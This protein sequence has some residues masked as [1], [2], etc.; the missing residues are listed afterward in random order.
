M[1]TWIW[2][3]A[4]TGRLEMPVAATLRLA[5]VV[6]WPCVALDGTVNGIVIAGSDVAAATLCVAGVTHVTVCADAVQVQGAWLEVRFPSVRNELS[7]PVT[8][9][10]PVSAEEPVFAATTVRTPVPPGAMLPSR[11]PPVGVWVRAMLSG[12]AASTCTTSFTIAVTAEPAGG[13]RLTIAMVV[14]GPAAS[15][16]GTPNGIEMGASEAPA[17]S[18]VEAETEAVQ[19]TTCATAPQA[20]GACDEARAPAVRK[21]LSWS[22]T[23]NTPAVIAALPVFLTTR[24]ITPPEP[25][26]TGEPTVPPF[27]M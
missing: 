22:V 19:V 14:M 6:I 20:H 7:C 4:A 2:S 13:A 11:A 24:V 18:G 3:V 10:A 12:G 9:K 23:V 25:A 5:V 16:A 8:V 15:A 27:G 21:E 26:A 17:A 1:A